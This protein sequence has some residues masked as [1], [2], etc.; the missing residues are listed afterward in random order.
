MVPFA[1]YE[2]PLQYEP[3]VLKEHLHTRSA[4]GL[5]DVSHMGQLALWPLSG[6]LEDAARALEGLVPVDILGLAVGRQRYALFTNVAGG[7]LDD[8]MVANRGDHLSLVVNAAC[9]VADEEH[10]RAHLSEI[11]RVERLDGPRIDCAAGSAG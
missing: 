3:G 1:G 7:I 11:C 4:A 5:F 2:M 10:L 6:R 9:K 8:L